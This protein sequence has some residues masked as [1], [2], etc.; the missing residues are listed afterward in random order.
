MASLT[1]LTR[2]LEDSNY[3]KSI[4]QALGEIAAMKL[5]GTRSQIE[6]NSVYFQEITQLFYSVKL[7]AAH[8][9][10][11]GFGKS[12]PQTPK[13]GK[14]I[15]ILIT[16]DSHLSGPIDNQ[17]T[18]FFIRQT[19]AGQPTG[20]QT[21]DDQSKPVVVDDKIVI[22]QIGQDL[23][24][25]LKYPYPFQV[26]HFGSENPNLDELQKLVATI[27]PYDKIL[28]YYAK[29]KTL[30]SQEPTVIDLTQSDAQIQGATA[31]VDFILEPELEKMLIFFEA[32]ILVLLIQSI[33]LQQTLSRL[34]SR[35]VSMNQSETN[36]DKQITVQKSQLIHL[37]K[38]IQNTQILETYS[39][40]ITMKGA[41]KG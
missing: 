24:K 25:A 8:K 32:Q 14:S 3:L 41:S 15:S 31:Q 6:H 39:G 29:F 28:V 34:G 1:Q 17:L 5:K 22:G 10:F 36:A 35:M 7:V 18:H 40:R 37:R 13:N 30:I 38:L 33:F 9:R 23:L 16:S 4:T 2:D 12:L 20:P 26:I 21:I 19:T 11:M 27:K